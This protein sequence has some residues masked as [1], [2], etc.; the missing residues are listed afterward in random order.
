MMPDERK[1][2]G[3][4]SYIINTLEKKMADFTSYYSKN[5]KLEQRFDEETSS[6]LESLKVHPLDESEKSMMK[7]ALRILKSIRRRMR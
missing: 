4:K 7:K 2:E 1:K 6:L 5:K 3:E